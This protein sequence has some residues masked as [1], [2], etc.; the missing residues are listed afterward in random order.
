MCGGFIGRSGSTG[1]H[2]G[3]IER[4]RKSEIMAGFEHWMRNVVQ[5]WPLLCGLNTVHPVF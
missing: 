1:W 4:L 5:K 2:G 3:P